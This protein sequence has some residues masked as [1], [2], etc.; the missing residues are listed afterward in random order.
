MPFTPRSGVHVG[1]SGRSTNV[2]GRH[3]GRAPCCLQQSN[4][5]QLGPRPAFPVPTGQRE[6]SVSRREDR[7]HAGHS[8]AKSRI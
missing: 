7:S 3:P 1:A 8:A 6:G 4:Q 5:Y 2:V